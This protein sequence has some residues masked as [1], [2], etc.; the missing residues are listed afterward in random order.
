MSH[1]KLP[2]WKCQDCNIK[3]HRMYWEEG[4]PICE[5]VTSYVEMKGGGLNAQE[6]EELK[7]EMELQHRGG[8]ERG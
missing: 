3:T 7:T 6:I 2:I 4:C 5:T 8:V 1:S